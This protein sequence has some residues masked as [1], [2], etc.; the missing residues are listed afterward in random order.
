MAINIH[1]VKNISQGQEI[2]TN[3]QE[4]DMLNEIAK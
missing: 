4:L 3:I 1:K 2:T